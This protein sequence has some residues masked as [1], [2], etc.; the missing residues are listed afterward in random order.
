MVFSLKDTLEF[1]RHNGSL[2][3]EK[4][5]FEFYVGSNRK[6]VSVRRLRDMGALRSR[7]PFICSQ[8][9][10]R[11]KHTCGPR[12]QQSVDSSGIRT[13]NLHNT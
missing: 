13:H 10:G 7:L 8:F 11:L 2:N 5:V 4:F 12:A 6:S 9:V 3:V 1:N